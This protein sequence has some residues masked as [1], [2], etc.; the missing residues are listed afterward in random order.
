[1]IE[2]TENLEKT[3]HLH[4]D[5]RHAFQFVGEADEYFRIWITNTALTLVSLGIYSAWAKVRARRYFY[6][7]TQVDGCKFEYH[8]EAAK[9]LKGRLLLVALLGAFLLGQ[10]A[11]PSVSTFASG[12][13]VIL[14]PWIVVRGQAFNLGNTSYRG[15]R[16]CFAPDYLAAYTAYAKGFGISAITLGLGTPCGVFW[17]RKFRISH[18]RYGSSPFRFSSNAKAFFPMYLQ[19]L[20]LFVILAISLVAVMMFTAKQFPDRHAAAAVA[21]MAFWPCVGIPL[22]F[23]FYWVRAAGFILAMNSTSLGDLKLE[24]SAKTRELAWVYFSGIAASVATLGLAYPWAKIRTSRY[25]ARRCFLR[26]EQDAISR[27]VS[28]P[29]MATGASADAAIDLLDIDLGF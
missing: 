29:S 21:K 26:G 19:A 16:F 3:D 18:T 11:F 28:A 25:K 2:S 15:V 17:D 23:S 12:L 13:A 14:F 24:T 6:G 10:F 22:A 7:C 1:M 20:G 9:I 5:V 8:G 4:T 27:F